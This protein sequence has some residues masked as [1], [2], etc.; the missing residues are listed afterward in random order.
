M[1]SIKINY[2]FPSPWNPRKPYGVRGFGVYMENKANYY[3]SFRD[4]I[5]LSM[6][7]YIYRYGVRGVRQKF[8]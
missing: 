4:I 8:V 3:L 6:K 5:S 7:T 2:S 1:R